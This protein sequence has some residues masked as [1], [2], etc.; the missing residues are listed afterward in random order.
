MK[1]YG[2]IQEAACTDSTDDE[3]DGFTT[4]PPPNWHEFR[5]PTSNR[6]RLSGQEYV[7]TR[8]K[9]GNITPLVVRVQE[10][11]GKAS[12]RMVLA[13]QLSTEY[14]QATQAREKACK[15]RNDK[16]GCIVQ[17]YREI[18][19]HQAR[20]QIVEDEEDEREVI[21]MREQRFKKKQEK[22][23]AAIAR[24]FAKSNNQSN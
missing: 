16:G 17:K 4:P 9:A 15:E 3:S 20:R 6:T 2:G 11:V 22:E 5:T 18:Y 7:A 13:G 8:L 19:G 21:N 1:E 14:L 24:A 10:K 12:D 23:E